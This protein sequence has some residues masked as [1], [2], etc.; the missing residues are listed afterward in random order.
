[1]F[2]EVDIPTHDMAPPWTVDAIKDLAAAVTHQKG[3][4]IPFNEHHPFPP[5]YHQLYQAFN[6][7]TLARAFKLKTKVRRPEFD[8]PRSPVD[9]RGY[10]LIAW[11]VSK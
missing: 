4:E 11:L 5:V 3:I 8:G 7:S 6:A 9:S 10:S 2:S 1:M